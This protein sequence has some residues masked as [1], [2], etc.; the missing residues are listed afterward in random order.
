[1]KIVHVSNFSIRKEGRFVFGIP[2]KLTQGLARLD[3]FVFNFSDRDVAAS[4]ILRARWLGAGHANRQLIR[5]CKELRP[6]LLLL[7][8]CCLITP[9]TVNAIRDAVRGIRIVHWNCD[10]LFIPDN[11]ERLA[12]LAPLVD[13]TLV[14]TAGE[15]QRELAEKG[16]RVSYMPNPVDR[17]IEDLQV[18]KKDV[19]PNDLIFLAGDHSYNSQRSLLC[20]QVRNA[21]P[22]LKFDVRG[23]LGQP[24]A[25]GADFFAALG[26]AKMGLNI[27][28]R[29]DIN[30]Y[31]SDRLVQTIGCGLLTFA[32]RATGFGALFRDDELVTYEGVGDLI[33]KLIYYNSHDAVRRDCARRGWKRAHRYFNSTLVAQW[34]LDAVF[35]SKPSRYYAWPTEILRAMGADTVKDLHA[36]PTW[37]AI[38]D[39]V[40][41]QR[42]ESCSSFSV[43]TD[44]S[45]VRVTRG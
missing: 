44:L 5:I 2:Y 32:D 23:I 10:A 36:D 4:S 3:H 45:S 29:N 12:E 37:R 25:Y 30:L 17:S 34:I 28:A 27:S 8:H 41:S 39:Y 16:G 22:S 13:L 20:E 35:D 9:E 40:R 24:R 26:N 42:A 33:D 6:D 19:V 31:S 21:I 43:R 1:M 11:F 15:Y 38:P 18:F 14:T 7:G